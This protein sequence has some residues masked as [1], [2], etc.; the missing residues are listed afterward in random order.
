MPT[1]KNLHPINEVSIQN[2]NNE[3][4]VSLTPKNGIEKLQ[5]SESQDYKINPRIAITSCYFYCT[6][7]MSEFQFAAVLAYNSQYQEHLS[8]KKTDDA[9]PSSHQ[10]CVPL[11]VLPPSFFLHIAPEPLAF[12]SQSYRKM[13]MMSSN[14]FQRQKSTY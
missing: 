2:L 1:S 13:L 3:Q 5:V 12:L 4:Y 9:I 8:P 7:G 11:V 14:S 6:N 10:P